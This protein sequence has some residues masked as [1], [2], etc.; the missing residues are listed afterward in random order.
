MLSLA[1]ED[2]PFTV[3]NTY[4]RCSAPANVAQIAAGGREDERGG[5]EREREGGMEGGR[6]GQWLQDLPCAASA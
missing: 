3:L 2:V 1:C 6:C 5:S 4:A